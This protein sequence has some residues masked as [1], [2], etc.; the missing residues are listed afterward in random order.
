M[1][2]T[3]DKRRALVIAT[4][5]RHKVSE[6]KELL[7]AAEFDVKHLGEYPGIPISP[8][9]GSTFVANALQKSLFAESCLGLP[10]F[11]DD[12]GIVVPS[13]GG[14]PGIYS[15]RYAGED[16]SDDENN[17]LLLKRMEGVENRLAFFSCAVAVVVPERHVAS[18]LW[19]VPPDRGWFALENE[20]VYAWTAEAAVF[21]SLLR[22]PVGEAGFGYDPLF[23]Y[24]P[25]GKTFAQMS[26]EEKNAISHRGRALRMM[27]PAL[28]G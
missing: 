22:G 9:T 20:G 13:L 1:S 17:D 19:D 4:H 23:F 5:N 8:E 10:C 18:G 21:G 15:A 26:I 6:M 11:A 25:A 14:A 16:A 3:G 24:E 28:V 12:S 2:G 27:I 7:P